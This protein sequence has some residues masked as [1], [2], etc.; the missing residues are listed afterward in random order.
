MTMNVLRDRRKNL[1]GRFHAAAPKDDK[2]RIVSVNQAHG[3]CAPNVQAMV[4]HREGEASPR[5]S[6]SERDR[7]RSLVSG[8]R[9]SGL[10]ENAGFSA[11]VA[12]KTSLEASASAQPDIAALALAAIEVDGEMTAQAT[13][14]ECAGNQMTLHHGCA[15]DSGSEGNNHDIVEAAGRAGIDVR[16][17]NATRASFSSRRGKF[18]STPTRREDRLPRIQDT[19]HWWKECGGTRNRPVRKS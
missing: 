1:L 19:F 5:N 8:K 3:T 15:A 6:T 11:Q 9:E 2:L 7:Q 18:K 10:R 17:N 14:L 4:A 12:A 13:G 16:P